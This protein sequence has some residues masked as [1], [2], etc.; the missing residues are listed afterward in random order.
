VKQFLVDFPRHDR[1]AE[2]QIELR[3]ITEG[4]DI[5]DL[6]AENK[7]EI[8]T[9]GSGL[10]RVTVHVRKLVPYPLVLRIPVGTYFVSQNMVVRR[11]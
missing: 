9:Q 4:R 6:L 2:A 1:E 11:T 3:D 7:I 5:I 8:E 10:E